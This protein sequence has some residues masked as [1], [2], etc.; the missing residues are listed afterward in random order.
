M[1]D[2]DARCSRDSDMSNEST[3]DKRMLY[4]KITLRHGTIKYRTLNENHFK[5]SKLFN[6]Y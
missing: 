3:N 5:V 2:D 1:N 4:L 6:E